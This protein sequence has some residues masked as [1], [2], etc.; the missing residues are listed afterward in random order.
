M[1]EKNLQHDAIEKG[2]D[3]KSD[4][5]F[6]VTSAKRVA[7]S[8]ASLTLLREEAGSQLSNKE[9]KHLTSHNTRSLCEGGCCK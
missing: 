7:V 8:Q 2:G 5:C 3:V 1:Q 4:Q 9:N 6:A